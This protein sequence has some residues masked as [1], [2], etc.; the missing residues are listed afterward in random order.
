[1]YEPVELNDFMAAVIAGA[2]VVLF[3]AL[4]AFSFAMAKLNKGWWLFVLAYCLFAAL[5]V[6]VFV[7]AQAL[8]LNGYWQIV[9]VAMLLGYLIAPQAIWKLSVGTHK[10][11]DA[12]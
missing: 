11:S 7:L 8:N 12:N 5:S 2:S 4:Y 6:S 9:T 3:G 10:A 1:V